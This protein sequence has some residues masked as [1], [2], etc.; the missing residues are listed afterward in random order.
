M[1]V[2]FWD[3]NMVSVM[4]VTMGGLYVLVANLILKLVNKSFTRYCSGLTPVPLP[5]RLNKD[6]ATLS[7][8]KGLLY[9]QFGFPTSTP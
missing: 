5:N 8:T 4:N 2:R 1:N 6:F 3:L 9:A 7:P